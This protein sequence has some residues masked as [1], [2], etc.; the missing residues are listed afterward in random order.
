MPTIAPAPQ[1]TLRPN[2]AS[3]GLIAWIEQQRVFLPLKGVECRFTVR[4]GI[5]EVE[6]DQIFHQDNPVPVDCQY[7]FPLPGDAAVYR[8]ELNV[9]S[10][11]L[12]AKVLE[13]EEAVKLAKEMKQA[14]HRTALVE[15]ERDNLFTLSLGNVQRGDLIVVRLSYI[16]P[17]QSSGGVSSL[18]I[19]LCPGVRYIPGTPLLRANRGAG[20]EDDTDEVPD[21][22]RITTPR[23]DK[24][25]P[26]AAYVS[27][28]GRFDAFAVKP[29]TINSPSHQVASAN[30]GS[31]IA[32]RLVDL[33][34]VPDQ[35][36]A[37]RWQDAL[38]DSLQPRGWAQCQGNHTYAL[39]ELRAPEPPADC[40]PEPMD[41]Y[42]MLD[43]SGSMSGLKWEKA[44]QAFR[45]T[46]NTLRDGDRVW[47]TVFESK[48]LDFDR[49]PVSPAQMLGDPL[50]W[51]A[52][53]LGTTGG[54]EIV[55]ALSHVLKQVERFS[56]KRR[57]SLLLLTDA[58]VGNDE[59]VLQTCARIPRLPIHCFG[60]DI[61]LNDALLKALARQQGG[62][63]H[64][65][66]P[67]DD[68]IG[69]VA[70]L[71]GGIRSPVLTD[72]SLSEGWE[73]ADGELQDLH[74]GQV[75]HVLARS[76]SVSTEIRVTGNDRTGQ[77]TEF[78]VILDPV[79][80][81][82]PHLLWCRRRINHLLARAQTKEAIELSKASN[83]V[84]RATAF[85]AWDE[86][87]KVVVATKT[88]VQ[89]ALELAAR[90]EQSLILNC[91]VPAFDAEVVQREMMQREMMQREMMQREALQES[92]RTYEPPRTPRRA[93][94]PRYKDSNAIVEAARRFTGELHECASRF[95]SE[96][97]RDDIQ[98]GSRLL[99]SLGFDS[100]LQRMTEL[101]ERLEKMLDRLKTLE[102][103]R[104][105]LSCDDHAAHDLLRSLLVSR[106][107]EME[108]AELKR[109]ID[110][111]QDAL[112]RL[113]QQTIDW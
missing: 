70:G 107:I 62:S 68:I 18:D 30:Q 28:E 89:P 92:N 24:L 21:A 8:C 33:D 64:S 61:A 54:T 106:R 5:V 40:V 27:I 34:Q 75:Q 51:E 77:P 104:L 111:I 38:V 15:S 69:I 52:L 4:G 6:L 66:H 35:D 49:Q 72:V 48:Y 17:F 58:Q 19:P 109:E 39:L 13:R 2:D 103:R 101:C 12:T 23:I 74:A 29:G 83:L 73:I 110:L 20:P 113:L 81:N 97:G 37:L 7:L 98:L 25:H 112:R 65:I 79:T 63:F 16:Q 46:L 32:V 42:F 84:C 3:I 31:M 11:V 105:E 82:S 45:E 22:S 94:G 41:F 95:A 56:S 93:I 50:L 36:F 96:V 108:L 55:P 57:A 59:A 80:E 88:V 10:R 1:T 14:G 90:A 85:F 102:Q 67:N 26:D 9:N 91:R 47:L 43:R 78:T 71:A 100:P 60:I 44:V 76:Q 86:Q 53:N 87:E 99:T